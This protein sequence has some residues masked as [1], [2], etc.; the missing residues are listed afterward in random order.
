MKDFLNS[1]KKVLISIYRGLLFDKDKFSLGRLTFIII[2]SFSVFTWTG[3]KDIPKTAE[4]FLM[5]S[6]GYVLGSKF[7][8]IA[9]KFVSKK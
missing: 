4:T 5:V 9:E 8:N 1:I 3:G 7:V 2:F 6:M